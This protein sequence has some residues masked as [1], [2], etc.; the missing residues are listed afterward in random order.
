MMSFENESYTH[1]IAEGFPIS[2]P[3]YRFDQKNEMFKRAIWDPGVVA[4]TNKYYTQVNYQNRPGYRQIDYALRNASWNLEYEVGWGNSQSNAGLYSWNKVTDK[5][6]RFIDAGEQIN[7][8]PEENSVIVKQAARYLGADLVGVCWAHPNLVYS[9]EFNVFTKEHYPIELPD[10]HKNAIVMA[11]AM[12]YES[13]RYSPSSIGGA[14]TGSGYSMM[15]FLA[16][17]VAAFIRGL[18]Y[19]AAPSGN[20][21][22][23]SIPLAIAAGLGELG[24][25]GLLITEKYGPRVRICKVF[26]DMPL[27]HDIFRPLGVNEFCNI[28]RK[29]AKHCPSRAISH[30][31]PTTEGESIAN[32]SGVLKWYIDPEKCLQFWAK[33]RMDCT[34]CIKI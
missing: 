33:N 12:D 13:M 34:N 8:S 9:H 17:R 3:N 21:T 23:L 4:L 28:C 2:V 32:H 26:T 1:K 14:A 18:G 30:N 20:D 7:Y 19:N 10:G 15:A 5:I 16:N 24:R 6:K 29:C 27:A 11:V 22:A 31:D 25:M